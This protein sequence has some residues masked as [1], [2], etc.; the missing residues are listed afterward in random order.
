M[1]KVKAR[2]EARNLDFIQGPARPEAR[3]F[4]LGPELGPARGPKFEIYKGPARPDFEKSRPVP[5]LL[6]IK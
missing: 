4:G 6:C 3:I 2:L 5:P 1:D